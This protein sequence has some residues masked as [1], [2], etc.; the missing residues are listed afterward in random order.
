MNE[1]RLVSNYTV[2]QHKVTKTSCNSDS[3]DNVVNRDF[4]REKSLNV[5]VSDLTYVNVSDKWNYGCLLIDFY[6]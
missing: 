5:V 6:S 2:K 3:V 1:L 4:D